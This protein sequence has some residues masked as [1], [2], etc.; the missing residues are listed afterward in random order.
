M[1]LEEALVAPARRVFDEEA[2]PEARR[3]C[4]I[5]PAALGESI[6]DIAALC[7]AFDQGSLL[8]DALNECQESLNERAFAPVGTPRP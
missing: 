2:L 8:D 3:V 7:A 6:G 4:R 5:V 1:R